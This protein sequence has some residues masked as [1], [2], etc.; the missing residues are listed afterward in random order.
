MGFYIL[1]LGVHEAAEFGGGC[2]ILAEEGR[3]LVEGFGF[4]FADYAAAFGDV[5]FEFAAGLLRLA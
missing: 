2:E 4:D 5:F 1:E 3:V